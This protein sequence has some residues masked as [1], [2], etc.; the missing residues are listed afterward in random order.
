[1]T[2]VM[3]DLLIWVKRMWST[4]PGPLPA[5][6]SSLVH[7]GRPRASRS[8][9][10]AGAAGAPGPTC[11]RPAAPVSRAFACPLRRPRRKF[12]WVPSARKDPSMYPERVIVLARGPGGPRPRRR[13][14]S[15]SRNR[16]PG[17]GRRA[18]CTPRPPGRSGAMRSVA[19]VRAAVSR[20]VTKLAQEAPTSKAPAVGFPVPGACPAGG[21]RLR[22]KCTPGCPSPR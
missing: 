21:W 11:P 16:R 20:A 3:T 12:H 18:C 4:S 2:S 10:R 8:C 7:Q 1:M 13:R 15:S 22:G 17:A 6:S 5:F 19:T 9:H 14:I